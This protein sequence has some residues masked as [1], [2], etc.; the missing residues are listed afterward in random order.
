VT[1]DVDD[2]LAKHPIAPA[3]GGTHAHEEGK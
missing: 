2:Y 3:A 1:T